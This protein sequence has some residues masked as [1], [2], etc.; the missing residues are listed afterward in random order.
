MVSCSCGA[1]CRRPCGGNKVDF[2]VPPLHSAAT[3]MGTG[4]RSDEISRG[5]E[6]ASWNPLI[7]NLGIVS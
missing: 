5:R 4:A 1:P 3:Q 7:P 2:A 6:E